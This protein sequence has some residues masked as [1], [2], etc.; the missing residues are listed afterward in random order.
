M[1]VVLTLSAV[2][3]GIVQALEVAAPFVYTIF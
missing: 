1:L 2:V 3:L